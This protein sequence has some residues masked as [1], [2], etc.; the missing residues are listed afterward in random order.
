MDRIDRAGDNGEALF[1]YAREKEQIDSYFVIDEHSPDYERLLP[2]GNVVKLYSD[3]H[4]RLFLQADN[5]ISSQSYREWQ[6]IIWYPYHYT[7]R[8]VWLT[9]L[10][11]FDH[12]YNEPKKYILI[13]PT[14]RQGLM[15][16]VWDENKQAYVWQ[17]KEDFL[18]SEYV[19]RYIS[20]LNNERLLKACAWRGYKL[21]FMPHAL[22]APYIEH[23]VSGKRC[24][25][26]G[27]EKSYR[28]AFAEGNLLVTDYSSV[29]FDFLYLKKPV[30]YYQFD[31][32]EFFAKHTYKQGFFDYE[33]DA[34]GEVIYDEEHLVDE[35]I[36]YMKNKCRP[37]EMYLQ[38]MENLFEHVD[39]DNCKRVFKK[40]M[41]AD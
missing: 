30:I 19:K 24:E 14:W 36:A 10:P 7:S 23:F 27:S 15:E 41:E 17:V 35:L 40:I 12:L 22:M 26:W 34:P 2:L 9:G 33:K 13:M 28:E 3:E 6:S 8:E 11:R 5:V 4:F 37:K 18:E 29:A 39:Q 38:R 21:A 20:L 16:Q 31:K 25:H 1:R 32:E